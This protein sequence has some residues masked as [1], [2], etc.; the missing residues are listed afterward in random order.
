[1]G[2]VNFTLDKLCIQKK[3]NDIKR[4]TTIIIIIVVLENGQWVKN[5]KCK[6]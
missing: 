6:F 5:L 1:M 4:I 3:S 2:E